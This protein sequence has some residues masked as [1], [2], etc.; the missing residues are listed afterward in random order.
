MPTIDYSHLT[1]AEKLDLIGEIWDSIDQETIALTDEQAAE[2]DRRL[3]TLD[4]D[5]KDGRDAAEVSAE[6]RRQYL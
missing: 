2:I 1:T 5:I 6:L 4:E 3:A